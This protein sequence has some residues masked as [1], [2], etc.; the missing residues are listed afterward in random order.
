MNDYSDEDGNT[1]EEEEYDENGGSSNAAMSLF[2]SYYGIVDPAAEAAK[3]NK[4]KGTIDDSD[5]D[6]QAYVKVI[7]YTVIVLIQL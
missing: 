6:S 4:P 5:F 1:S 3:A 2:A 7:S